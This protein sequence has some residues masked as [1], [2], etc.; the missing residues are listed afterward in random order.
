[1]N[2]NMFLA[3]HLNKT[4]FQFYRKFSSRRTPPPNL[5]ACV[6]SL[7]SCAQN[8]ELLEGRKVHAR[9]IVGGHLSSP[10]SATSLINMY[11][12][13]S[14]VADA[15]SVFNSSKDVHNVFVYNSIIAG[16]TANDFP[17]EAFEFYRQMR[18]CGVEPDKF[19][20][21][22]AIKACLD[23]SDL[24]NIHGLL[25]KFKLN[26][27]P[28]IGS[29]LLHC[30][31]KFE[32][33]YDAEQLFE[34]MPE[35][36]DT[37]LWNAMINGF[38][39]IGEFGKALAIFRR[40]VEMGLVPNEFS[41]TGVLSALT[42]AADVYNGKAVHAFVIKM[43]HNV[44]IE[45]SNVL[46]DMYGKCK[47]LNAAL[48]VFDNMIERDM[49]S[50]NTIV[51]L[52]VRWGDQNEALRLLKMM[53]SLG[54]QPDVVTVTAALPAC[55]YLSALMRGKE[56]H[57]Y[58]ICKGMHKLGSVNIANAIMD[59]Y[60]KCGSLRD[61]RMVFDETEVKDVASWNI[62]VMC[63]GMHGFG[64]EA[65]SMFS[66]MCEGGLK[67]DAVSFVGVLTA[68]SHAGFLSRGQEI[69][70]EMQPIYGVTPDITHYAC[71]IDMLG[72]GGKLEEAFELMSHMPIEPNHVV[73]RSFLAACQVHGNADMAKVASERVLEL[74][75][76]HSGNYVLMSNVFGAAGRY[77]EVA[78]LRHEMRQKDVK[79]SPGCSWIELTDG[80]RVFLN[81]DC[82][83][84]FDD[85]LDTLTLCLREHGL[86][87]DT[88]ESCF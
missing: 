80:V 3:M 40:L 77:A 63:Y 1:M 37:V 2:K 83:E 53:V 60:A 30:Y 45:V 59:M 72:R 24:R 28:Y 42:L 52:H 48:L 20:F 15:V 4:H 49:Y 65:L 46:I 50:W 54:F 88:V 78:E 75:P 76:N 58:M 51:S 32:A 34:R 61:A 44:G 12:K 74:E 70:A 64:E 86:T 39:Q 85:G 47:H 73:W 5:Q 87:V 8:R 25:Y 35:R 18:S 43:G 62:I 10:V 17:F 38:V 27:D 79:K 19:T 23:V 26:C 6:A 14:S 56:I 31:L 21:P 68:C 9:M 7:Q 82:E 13:C 66:L 41:V 69:L 33:M 84:N 81:G 71:V 22:C 36:D 11:S 55:S 29:A 16:L 67:P 57:G